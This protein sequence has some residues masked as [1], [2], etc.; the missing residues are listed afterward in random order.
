MG[1]GLRIWPE[2]DKAIGTKDGVHDENECTMLAFLK[3]IVLG[4]CLLRYEIQLMRIGTR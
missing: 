1:N 3:N 2:H 4:E